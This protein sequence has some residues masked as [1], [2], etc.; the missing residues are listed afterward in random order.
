[1]IKTRSEHVTPHFMRG[2]CCHKRNVT[3]IPF[4]TVL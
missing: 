3:S 4:S 2:V 1:M